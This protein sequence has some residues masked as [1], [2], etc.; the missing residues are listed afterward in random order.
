MGEYHQSAH[1]CDWMAVWVNTASHVY[2]CPGTGYYGNTKSS[3]YMS[4][5]DALAAGHRPAGKRLVQL[6]NVRPGGRE[7][8]SLNRAGTS[9]DH[10][11]RACGRAGC[12]KPLPGGRVQIVSLER[13]AKVQASY[14]S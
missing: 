5:Q 9:R 4:E 11:G 13:Y 2:H 6:A 10:R 3:T 14:A 12:L 1:G 7:G 8:A